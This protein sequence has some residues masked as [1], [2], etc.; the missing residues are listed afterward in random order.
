MVRI[1][2]TGM[3][4]M[5]WEKPQFLHGSCT[6]TWQ[7]LRPILAAGHEVCLV[8]I[9]VFNP[10]APKDQPLVEKKRRDNLTYYL[11]DEL[12]RFVY[13]E[14]HQ[15]LIDR[16][17]PEAIIAITTPTMGPLGGIQTSA[18]IWADIHGYVMGESQLYAEQRKNDFFVYHFWKRYDAMLRRADC[19][20]V[21]SNIQRHTLVGELG[22]LGRLNQHT[23]GYEFV[24]SMPLGR[25]NLEIKKTATLLRGE[26]IPPDAFILLWLGGYND[27]C[28]PV[29][30]FQ[31]V[32]QAMEKNPRIHYVSTG[33]QIHGVND[34]TFPRLKALV[35]RSPHR[36]RFHFQGWVPTEDV[37]N[38]LAEADAGIN[39]DRVCY[40]SIYGARH[41]IIE[42]LRAGLPIVTT[43]LTEISREVERA[44]AGMVFPAEDP[45]NLAEAILEAAEHPGVLMD[46]GV[47]GQR[48]F[49]EKF[50]DEVTA[51]PLLEWLKNPVHAPDW[52]HDIP[53]R[54]NMLY[55]RLQSRTFW[56]KVRDHWQSRRSRKES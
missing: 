3:G 14:F 24:Y 6:R 32:E 10:N 28:D 4:P 5:Q 12:Q 39:V 44:G 25:E 8:A 18:P 30:L 46:M 2:A 11:V 23:T 49:L 45:E 53:W 22:A 33:G 37:S 20:S 54:E 1:Y 41:R 48:L 13:P 9:R 50:T 55:E 7:L 47:H 31:G 52:G 19:F 56:Q 43:N 16:F 35:D 36:D 38:Y 27:W 40:E 29:T 17:A 21:T 42:M 15:Q 34:V 26:S 51:A